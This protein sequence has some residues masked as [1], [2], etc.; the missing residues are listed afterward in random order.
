M[1]IRLLIKQKDEPMEDDEEASPEAS[2]QSEPLDAPISQ[3]A[4]SPEPPAVTT[5]GRRRGRRKVMKKKT[6][7]DEEG[8]LGPPIPA[9]PRTSFHSTK[10]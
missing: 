1:E 5:E 8:Y 4:A 2:Q 7:K 10:F 6:M 3:K 9:T